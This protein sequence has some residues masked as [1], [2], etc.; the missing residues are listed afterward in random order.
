M[1]SP[2]L[3]R[4]G[5]SALVL[6]AVANAAAIVLHAPQ[7]MDL[8]AF[9]ALPQGPWVTAHWLFVIGTT[10]TAGGLLALARHLF[11]TS[12]EGW[13][14]LGLGS[15]I[16]TSGVF[17]AVAAP[18]ILAFPVLEQMSNTPVPNDIYNAINLNLMS[19]VHVGLPVFAAGLSFYG[20]AM[21]GDPAIPRWMGQAG[22]AMG[23]IGIVSNW[24]LAEQWRAFQAVF[25]LQFAW[26]ALAGRGLMGMK[27]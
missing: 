23:I 24:L 4:V 1:Q 25:V 26:L 14:V 2:S 6:G 13:A 27:K 20:L 3:Y 12:G 21:L 15:T 8:A 17:V 19:S 5:G 11:N 22:I 7:P 18:E 16:V 10:F 9:G